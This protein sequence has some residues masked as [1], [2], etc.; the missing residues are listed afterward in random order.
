[1]VMSNSKMEEVMVAGIAADLAQVKLTLQDLPNRPGIAA[2]VFGILAEEAVVVDI[3]VQDQPAAGKLTLS[4]TVGE[5][6][7]LKAKMVLGGKVKQEFP[8]MKILEEGRLA[9]V[10]AVG[11]G[12]QHHPGVAAK[13]FSLLAQA[14]VDIK[15]ITTS[16]IKISCLVAADQ[17]K[18]AVDALH[19]GFGLG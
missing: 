1:M 11:V 17:A 12:M 2:M 3:I 13:M 4:F 14:G 6:D 18:N 15:L 8:E 5:P 19:R 9:K 10:S 7:A 16:E